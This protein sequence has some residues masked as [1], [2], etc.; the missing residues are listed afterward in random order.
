MPKKYLP[1]R[2]FGVGEVDPEFLMRRD[3][4]QYRDGAMKFRDARLIN[5]GA[6]KRRPGSSW[7]NTL[8]DQAVLEGFFFN[9]TQE[10]VLAFR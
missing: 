5:S 10:Y 4:E 2:T 7:V 6:F 3:T 8:T 9:E 1:K